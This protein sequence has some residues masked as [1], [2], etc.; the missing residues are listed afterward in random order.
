MLALLAAPAV[1]G[2]A[3]QVAVQQVDGLDVVVADDEDSA[4]VIDVRRDIS[5]RPTATSSFGGACNGLQSR[6]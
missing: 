3:T 4:A 5:T 1:A 6:C 2:A